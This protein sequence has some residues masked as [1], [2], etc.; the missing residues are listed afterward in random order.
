MRPVERGASPQAEDFKDYRDAFGPLVGRLGPYCSFCERRIATQLAV[1]HI[2]PKDKTRYPELEGRWENYLLACVNCNS[3]KGHK[4]VRPELVY[5]PDRDN[6]LAAFTYEAD[7]SVRQ[8]HQGDGMATAT[9]SLTGLE[10]SVRQVFDENGR[11]VAADRIGQRVEAWLT[12]TQ[13]KVWLQ[14]NPNQEL[15]EAIVKLA[16]KEGFFGVWMTV[17]ADDAEMRRRFVEAFPGTATACFTAG[18]ALVSPRPSNGLSG[19][20]KI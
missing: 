16:T 13:A 14:R 5:L 6:T 10:K 20:G 19:G 8:G 1:E 15:I 11:L 17:F 7:G 4:D 3:T 18:M 2:Q 12:A 9:L